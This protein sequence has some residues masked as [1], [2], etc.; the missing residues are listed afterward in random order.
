[1]NIS[2]ILISYHKNSN[3]L[4]GVE[5]ACFEIYY[6]LVQTASKRLVKCQVLFPWY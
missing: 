5:R 4:C 6:K 2:G 1:M 3:Y